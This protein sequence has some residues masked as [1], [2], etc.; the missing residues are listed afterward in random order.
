MSRVKRT[1]TGLMAT[2]AIV[3][4]VAGIPLGLYVAGGAPWPATVPS[5]DDITGALTS[6]DDGTAFM[7]V[8]KVV[9]WLAWISFA[10][11]VLLEIAAQLRGVQA[12]KI[13]ALG[14]QQKAAAGLVGAAALL[15]TA[16]PLA[17]AST[18]AAYAAEPAAAPTTAASTIV[19]GA[20][21]RGAAQGSARADG[22][23][24]SD[25]GSA[26]K[27]ASGSADSRQVTEDYVVRSGDTLWSIA[28]DTLGDGARFAEI[29]KLNYDR[30]QPDGGALSSSH[31]I[32]PGW[33]LK[34]PVT[35]THNGPQDEQQVTVQPGDS[36]SEIAQNELGDADRWPDLY[37]ASQDIAQPGGAQLS[38]PDLIIP[39]WT[40]VLPGNESTT[41][42][43]ESAE[44]QP[45]AQPETQSET[46]QPK[47]TGEQEPD[48]RETRQDDRETTQTTDAGEEASQAPTHDATPT[49]ESVDDVA[50]DEAAE[51]DAFPVR[52]VAGVGSLLAAGVLGLVAARRT[53]QRRRHRPGQQ[54]VLPIGETAEV[55]QELRAT[56]DPLSVEAV[57][58][59]LRTLAARCAQTQRPLPV[60]RAGRLTA[61]QFDLYLAEPAQLPAPWEGTADATVWTLPGDAED[62]LGADTAQDVPSPYPALVTIGH[63]D[64]DGHVFLDLEYL[65]AL[66]V[67]GDPEHTRQVLAAVAVE[68]AT[69]RW[70]DDLQ[71]TIVGAYPELEDSL[72]TGRVRYMPA[73]GRLLEELQRRADVDREQLRETGVEDLQ[74]A[75][76]ARIAPGAW[77]PEIVL[78]AGEISDTHRAQLEQLVSQVPRV[79][80]AAVTHGHV[81][82]EWSINLTEPQSGTLEPIGLHLR[83]QLLDDSTYAQILAMLA[84]ADA[85]LVD[86]DLEATGWTTPEPTLADLPADIQDD[87]VGVEF[88]ALLEESPAETAD[89]P[90]EQHVDQAGV[91]VAAHEVDPIDEPVSEPTAGQGA[92]DEQPVDETGVD[93]TGVDQTGV[94]QTGVDETGVDETGVDETGVDV[95]QTGTEQQQLEPD[96]A[97]D[98]SDEVLVDDHDVEQE[99]PVTLLPRRGPRIL[100]MGSVEIVDATGTVEPSKKGRL[101]ELAAFLAT[102]PGCDHTLI[103]E[104]QWPGNP[105]SDNTRNTAMSK[106]RRWMGKTAAGDDFL[107]RY[108]SDAGYRMHDEV[109]TD[110]QQWQV[111]LPS[112]AE[113]ATTSAI[114]EALQLVRGRPFDGVRARR[115]AWAE[116]LRQEMIIAILDASYELAR[117]RLMDGRW[118]AAGSA[119]LLGLSIEPAYERLWRVRILAAHASGHPDAVSQAVERLL[120]AAE[121]WGGDLDEETEELLASLKSAPPT[122]EQLANGIV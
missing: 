92:I 18:G 39:G 78:L 94:D 107:P 4:L 74:H 26:G 28:E 93:Q 21:D 113:E 46:Q 75:R 88:R 34:V 73:P 33:S 71:V 89:T 56:A 14:F 119:A 82:G 32:Q 69:S 97:D 64:E 79:A 2:I 109:T 110:W 12:P 37:Q 45:K 116:N 86:P 22:A 65:G 91:D 81:V 105:V 90:D 58:L 27:H 7:A 115:Y 112:G 16:M 13:P 52:T 95:D 1:F 54:V 48:E 42:P 98:A 103:D 8:L 85:D 25:A 50:V 9:G 35:T 100:L 59:A 29:A 31:W 20:S 23:T 111:L 121:T 19:A 61:D 99:A 68:L 102:H 3:V 120:A 87:G 41:Q 117:R 122:R 44:P 62:Q 104:A 80:I 60:V 15:F 49:P 118:R 114:E 63:D 11:M 53:R 36:L 30:T 70:A 51:D 83:P 101:T 106:L 5:V 67:Q 72:E 10:A 6:P 47:R 38:D 24:Q 57:D 77:T 66:G 55:E 76:I 84:T 40:V 17:N 108:Q 43:Q 96:Q